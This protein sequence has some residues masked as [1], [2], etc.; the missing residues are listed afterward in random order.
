MKFLLLEDNITDAE[1]T[2]RTLKKTWTDCT[3]K[4]IVTI[5]EATEILATNPEFDIALLDMHLPDGNGMDVLFEIRHTGADMAVVML[6]GSGDEEVAVAALKAGADD[7][8]V[9]QPGYNAK[10]P[11]VVEFALESHRQFQQRMSSIIHVLYIE[12]N[13]SDVDFTRRYLA[14]YAPYIRL[15][16]VP[17]GEEALKI[18]PDKQEFPEKWKYR[19]V[20]MDYRLPGMTA[21]D[22]IKEIRLER[23]LDIPIIIVTGHGNEEV[24]VQALK[25]GASDYLVKRENYLARFPSLISGAY[26]HCELKRKQKALEES[27]AK[28][29]LL[30]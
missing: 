24:A 26:E 16:D 23:K 13:A 6:T 10:I 17:T 30:A 8:M 1:L 22:I 15:K 14:R 4:H 25:V 18:L 3:V 21:L 5:G 9:K 2:I 7:Y 27:E 19:V 29:R 11:Q 28:Y 20:L 12:H